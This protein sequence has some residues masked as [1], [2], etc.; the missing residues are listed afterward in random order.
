M[1]VQCRNCIY[2]IGYRDFILERENEGE[3]G[4]E[5]GVILCMDFGAERVEESGH[6]F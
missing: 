3:R 5:I 2:N 6:L 1:S 4:G